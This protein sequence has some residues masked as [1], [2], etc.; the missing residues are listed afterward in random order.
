M[1]LY[2]LAVNT[3]KSASELRNI[4]WITVIVTL[5]RCFEGV[6]RYFK[7]PGDVRAIASVVLEHDDSLFIVVAI[8][9]LVAV[10]LWRRWLPKRLFQATLVLFP[11]ALYIMVINGRRAAFLC[12]FIMLATYAPLLWIS[13]RSKLRKRQMIYAAIACAIIGPIY[14]AAFWKKV[15]SPNQRPR[16]LGYPAER[17]RLPV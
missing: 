8:G 12:V 16:A 1:L 14:L 7:M 4:I 2:V 6:Y 5:L 10:V 11:F 15:G 17:A 13:L 3:V 9:L